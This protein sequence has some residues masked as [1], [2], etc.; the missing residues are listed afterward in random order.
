METQQELKRRRGTS[1]MAGLCVVVLWL[2]SRWSRCLVVSLRVDTGGRC[3][4]LSG[5]VQ[6][7]LGSDAEGSPAPLCHQDGLLPHL[8]DVWHANTQTRVRIINCNWL[9]DEKHVTRMSPVRF[10]YRLWLDVGFLSST[11]FLCVSHCSTNKMQKKSHS[12]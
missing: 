12:D 1:R 8:Q 3:C 5:L 7:A 6:E 4:C 11:C 2:V 10:L 9:T